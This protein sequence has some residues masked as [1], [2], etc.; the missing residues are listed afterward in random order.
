[1]AT[2]RGA[3]DEMV[4]LG[5]ERRAQ[6]GFDVD[7][8]RTYADNRRQALHTG[9][10]G[11]GGLVGGGFAARLLGLFASPAFGQD[12]MDVSAAQTAASIEN[13]AVT[14]YNQAAGLP[15]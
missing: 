12:G 6:G 13:L 4:E 10:L 14:V 3:L 9:L 11:L 15:F 7:E 5:H 8:L 1:M 2:T